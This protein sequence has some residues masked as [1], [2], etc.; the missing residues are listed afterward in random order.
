MNRGAFVLGS[1]AMAS[2]AFVA[3]TAR[4]EPIVS[5]KVGIGQTLDIVQVLY[6]VK[7]RLF[8]KT[9]LD[10]EVVPLV[11]GAAISAAVA[12]GSLQ[13][14]MSSLQGLISGHVHGI[15]F[16]LIGP[17][18]VY[19]SDDPYAYMFVRKDAPFATARDLNGKIF[20]SPALKD[21]D[22]LAN[23]YW[24]EKNGGDFKTAKA[25][26]MPNPSLLPA[27]IEGRIDAY[28]VGEPW[29]TIAQDSGKVRIFARSFEAIAPTFLMT[30]WFGTADYIAQN[31]DVVERFVR[32]L[33]DASVYASAHKAEMVPIIAAQLKLDP[34]LIAR[35]M[36]GGPGEYLEP[37]LVQPM[38]D[39]AAKYKIIDKGF[40]ATDIINP[41]TL[42]RPR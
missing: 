8:S 9:G 5:L 20:A 35:S 3:R 19:T 21:L 31:R 13:I 42:K 39:A 4:A 15:S 10:V 7:A 14:G 40:P 23:A 25:V 34:S 12:G 29:S 36:K 26:E 1:A 17:T 22:W 33:H 24:M 18:A 37:G 6:G 2:T 27:L 28:T 16:Q 30:G 32:V 41:V 38:I 11:N